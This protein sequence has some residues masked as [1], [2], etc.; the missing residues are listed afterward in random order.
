MPTFDAVAHAFRYL[1]GLLLFAL[2]CNYAAAQHDNRY[3]P[4]QADNK[5]ALHQHYRDIV[6]KTGKRSKQ[7]KNTMKTLMGA[8]ESVTDSTL[9]ARSHAKIRTNAIKQHGLAFSKDEALLH[10]FYSDSMHRTRWQWGVRGDTIIYFVDTYLYGDTSVIVEQIISLTEER[11]V[12]KTLSRDTLST[13]VP[14]YTRPNIHSALSMTKPQ[15][16]GDMQ[17]YLREGLKGFNPPGENYDVLVK[18]L[19]NC[20]EK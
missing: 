5:A 20:K 18:F 14:C 3:D 2:S 7:E 8:W 15:Y 19:V 11:V 6:L 4:A 10:N 1:T 13:A 16:P 17:Q 12:F 9:P